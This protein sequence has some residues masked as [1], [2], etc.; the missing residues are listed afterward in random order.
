MRSKPH[1]FYFGPLVLGGHSPLGGRRRPWRP[2]W[3]LGQQ[4][5]RTPAGDRWCRWWMA[6][7]VK[8][9]ASG[10][11]SPK[12]GCFQRRRSRA[13]CI[14]QL[15]GPAD[16]RHSVWKALCRGGTGGAL[17]AAHQQPAPRGRHLHREYAAIVD[18]KLGASDGGDAG[19]LV[20]AV[21]GHRGNL[22]DQAV[23]QLRRRR[24]TTAPCLSGQPGWLSA[25]GWH[26]AHSRHSHTRSADESADPPTL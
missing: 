13:V 24:P 26:H 21:D 12:L 18:L 5:V 9:A 2:R 25:I 16:P 23:A 20:A 10:R 15:A 11:S 14:R 1:T 8:E 4:S 19:A 17:L 6:G 22:K 3:R 7:C